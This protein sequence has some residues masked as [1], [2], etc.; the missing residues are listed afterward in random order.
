MMLKLGGLAINLTTET[1][2]KQMFTLYSLCKPSMH[3][4][5]SK[6]DIGRRLISP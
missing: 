4:Y 3:I 6:E 2:R 5:P 1:R